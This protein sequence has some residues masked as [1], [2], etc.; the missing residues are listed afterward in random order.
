LETHPEGKKTAL[1]GKRNH[2]QGV[3]CEDDLLPRLPEPVLHRHVQPG[4]SNPLSPI[5]PIAGHRLR[6]GQ[7]I[8]CERAFLPDREEIAEYRKTN[9]ALFSLESQRPLYDFDILAFS[10]PFEN[11]YLN[12]LTIL[13]MG[14]IPLLRK[15]RNVSHPLVIAGGVAVFLNPEP[16]CDFFDSFLIGEGEEV[17]PELDASRKLD[18]RAKLDESSWR[19]R[20]PSRAYTSPNS[21]RS[22]ISMKVRSKASSPRATT[23]GEF[24]RGGW[25]IS[26]ASIPLPPYSPPIPSSMI[27]LWLRLIG[28]A[29]G[30]AASALAASYTVP[31]GIEPWKI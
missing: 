6:E 27:W 4:V 22:G 15:A 29:P 31:F 7:D 13:E 30:D 9:T 11:D 3:E 25:G 26:I 23:P 2:P 16:L 17:L 28:V 20:R 12:I 1:R 10:L 5:E 24:K 14:K 8:V 19:K 18:P 21:I